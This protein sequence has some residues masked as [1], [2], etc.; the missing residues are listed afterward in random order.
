MYRET[1]SGILKFSPS[2]LTVFLTTEFASWMDRWHVERWHGNHEVVGANGLPIGLELPGVDECKRDEPDEQLELIKAKGMEHENAFL[3]RL[4]KKGHDIAEFKTLS[5]DV[6][7]TVEAMRQRKE[8]IYQARLEQE[9]FA[10]YAD[11][12]ARR[13]GESLL[14]NHHYEAWDTK[15]SRSPKGSFIIQ[16]CAYSEMLEHL[17]GHRPDEFEVVLGAMCYPPQR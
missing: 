12:L 17:Q 7:E 2:D 8:F 13:S 14:G 16:L 15:L 10:G 3:D 9:N 11:F 6:A 5:K 1:D 4:R